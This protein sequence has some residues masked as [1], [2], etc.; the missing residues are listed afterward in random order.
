MARERWDFRSF[1][2][3][4]GGTGLSPQRIGASGSPF[5]TAEAA[6]AY[7][8]SQ[9]SRRRELQARLE[10][11]EAVLARWSAWEAS[12]I[13]PSNSRPALRPPTLSREGLTTLRQLLLEELASLAADQS[14]A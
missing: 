12:R 1:A 3:S 2:P 8:R 10:R 14:S 11:V 9:S 4:A 7:L 6:E 5:S 13:A